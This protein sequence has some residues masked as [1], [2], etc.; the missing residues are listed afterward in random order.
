[1][2]KSKGS[3]ILS[4]FT[5]SWVILVHHPKTNTPGDN[6]WLKHRSSFMLKSNVSPTVFVAYA[7]HPDFLV[8]CG[9]WGLYQHC[10]YTLRFTC[11]F[12]MLLLYFTHAH[13]YTLHDFRACHDV[14]QTGQNIRI[15]QC[16]LVILINQTKCESI[17]TALTEEI[18][19][20]I[21]LISSKT[22]KWW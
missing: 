16:K 15:N 13:T 10:H 21:G 8:V 22:K 6:N 14:L 11:P 1:M 3:F 5:E 18:T 2:S 19:S 4:V 20:N 12:F 9:Y 17:M 7:T